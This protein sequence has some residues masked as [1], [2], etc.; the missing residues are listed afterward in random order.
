MRKKSQADNWSLIFEINATA[1]KSESHIWTCN[2]HVRNICFCL[3]TYRL[4]AAEAGPL[5]FP[6]FG[7]EVNNCVTKVKINI[8][9]ESFASTCKQFFGGFCNIVREE[10]AMRLLSAVQSIRSFVAILIQF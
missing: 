9:A 3:Q 7:A 4:G 10:V 1:D 6:S 2:L 8:R 5:G